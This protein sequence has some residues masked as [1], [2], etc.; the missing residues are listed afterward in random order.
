MSTGFWLLTAAIAGSGIGVMSAVGFSVNGF[1][2]LGVLLLVWVSLNLVV[3]PNWL[4]PPPPSES[5]FWRYLNTFVAI[6]STYQILKNGGIGSVV[7][8]AAWLVVVTL[9]LFRRRFW[10]KG[11]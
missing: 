5:K 8:V 11:S 1:I 2:L 3:G 9:A 10:Q 6:A 7:V 4:E